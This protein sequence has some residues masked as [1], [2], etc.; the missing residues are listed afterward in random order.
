MGRRQRLLHH[1]RALGKD[2]SPATCLQV[3]SAR[4]TKLESGVVFDGRLIGVRQ[5]QLT[6]QGV[7]GQ[8]A[9]RSVTPTARAAG[10]SALT[11]RS[12]YALRPVVP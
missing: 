9:A 2:G 3:R 11:G 5:C 4:L 6:Q 1:Y 12:I 7:L 10:Q 8:D